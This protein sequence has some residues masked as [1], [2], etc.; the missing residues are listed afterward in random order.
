MY[1]NLL[2]HHLLR[3]KYESLEVQV[4]LTVLCTSDMLCTCS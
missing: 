3:V 4:I 2:N 1:G